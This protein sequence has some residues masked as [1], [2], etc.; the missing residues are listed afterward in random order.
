M[1]V[2]VE[3]VLINNFIIDYVLLYLSQLLAKKHVKKTSTL[4]A[5]FIGAIISLVYP[6]VEKYFILRGDNYGKK[7]LVIGRKPNALR[8]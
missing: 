3:Y 5:S 6:L 8:R 2:Y 7:L 1:T 4:I